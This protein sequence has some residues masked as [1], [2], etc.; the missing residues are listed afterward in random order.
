MGETEVRG[1]NGEEGEKEEKEGIE[2]GRAKS[3][4]HL[5]GHL[6]T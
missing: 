4:G 6:E 2:G 5:K 1:S 3:K